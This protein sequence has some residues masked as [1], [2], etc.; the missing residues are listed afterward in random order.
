MWVK[1][2]MKLIFGQEITS[3]DIRGALMLDYES[4]HDEYH[5]MYERCLD[6]QRRNPYI[7]T[8][9]KDRGEIVGYINFSPVTEAAYERLRRGEI[10]TFVSGADILPMRDHTAYDIYLSSI[11]VRDDYRGR[12]CAGRMMQAVVSEWSKLATERDVTVRRIVADAISPGGAHLCEALGLRCV[13]H[14]NRDTLTYEL[15]LQPFS[16]AETPLNRPLLHP[17]KEE[18]R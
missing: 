6:Y 10:D 11:V 7:Y 4:Y 13:A 9:L 15:I 12:G 1:L 18:E 3:E 17:K 16:G 14:T 2:G 8:M 5:L